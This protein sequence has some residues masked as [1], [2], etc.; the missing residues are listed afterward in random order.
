MSTRCMVPGVL[1]PSFLDFDFDPRLTKAL[2]ALMALRSPN[3]T[4]LTPLKPVFAL[5]LAAQ[6]IKFSRF[7]VSSISSPSKIILVFRAH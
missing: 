3:P 5:S 6:K 1:E 4:E 7:D 2:R